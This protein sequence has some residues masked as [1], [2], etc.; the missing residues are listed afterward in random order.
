M[1]DESVQ[2][3]KDQKIAVKSNSCETYIQAEK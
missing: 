1:N 3:T 2:I